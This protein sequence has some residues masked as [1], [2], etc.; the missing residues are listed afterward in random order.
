M[1][2]GIASHKGGVGKTT[3]AIHLSAILSNRSPCL[4]IDGDVNRSALA[5]SKRSTAELPFRVVDEKAAHRYTPDYKNIVI[6][7]GAHPNKGDLA[8]IVEGCDRLVIITEPEIMS[9]DV[10]PEML[11]DLEKLGSK[12]HRVLLCQVDPRSPALDAR[13]VIEQLGAR[14]FKAHVRS[15]AAYKL[16]AQRGTT[17]N[18]IP[19]E[20]SGE[21]WADYQAVARELL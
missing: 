18:E 4:L 11:A 7:T 2:I 13:A 15:Y 9:L 3:T 5:Y 14:V 1:I 19:G 20:Y 16:A 17:V 6:D 8:A 21:A 12:H 10:L